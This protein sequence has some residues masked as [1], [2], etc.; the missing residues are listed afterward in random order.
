M[1]AYV[2]GK[3]AATKTVDPDLERGTSETNQGVDPGETDD[4]TAT[5]GGSGLQSAEA[6]VGA[7]EGG[8]LHGKGAVPQAAKVGVKRGLEQACPTPTPA[9][10]PSQSE[11]SLGVS[12]STHMTQPGSETV[13]DN[14]VHTVNNSQ[15]QLFVESMAQSVQLLTQSTVASQK[16]AAEQ[17]SMLLTATQGTNRIPKLE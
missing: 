11:Q 15:T 8:T 7:T 17:T 3:D 5:D 10:T 14:N 1:P 9:A 2:D 13:S 6:G 12:M 16:L 4:E